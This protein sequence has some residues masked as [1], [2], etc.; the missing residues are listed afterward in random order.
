MIK[1]SRQLA[2]LFTPVLAWL[3]AGGDDQY[4]FNME[5]YYDPCGS[6]CCIVGALAAFHPELNPKADEHDLYTWA[7]QAEEV[8]IEDFGMNYHDADALFY[9]WESDNISNTAHAAKRI[10]HW[11]ETGEVI[12]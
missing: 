8:L 12:R 2:A 4:T 9:N 11:I 10:R 3:D 5:T 6:T 7:M 1:P